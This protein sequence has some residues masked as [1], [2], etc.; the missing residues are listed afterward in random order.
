MKAFCSTPVVE[1]KRLYYVTQA[2]ELICANVQGKVEWTYDM[3]KELKV[4]PSISP[5][6][7]RSSSA[8][9]SWS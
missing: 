5:T 6:A 7:R 2:C 9:W 4:V 8:I 1:G 3:M